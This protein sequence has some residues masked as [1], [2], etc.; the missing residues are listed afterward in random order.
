[1]K[2]FI[3]IFLLLPMIAFANLEQKVTAVIIDKQ[4]QM[5]LELVCD[6]EMDQERIFIKSKE[7][8]TGD[9]IKVS[10]SGKTF[11]CDVEKIRFM[12]T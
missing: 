2:T 10:Q 1:M 6:K 8:K 7:F 9:S 11:Q 4:Y 3:A 12:L 5:K